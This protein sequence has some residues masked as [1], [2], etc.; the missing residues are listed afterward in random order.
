[1]KTGAKIIFL[2]EKVVHSKQPDSVPHQVVLVDLHAIYKGESEPWCL[3]CHEVEL[4]HDRNGKRKHAFTPETGTT[5]EVTYPDGQV[6]IRHHV[7]Q[8]KTANCWKEK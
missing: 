7:M 3:V 2:I 8:G 6:E 5:I 4:G 1:M